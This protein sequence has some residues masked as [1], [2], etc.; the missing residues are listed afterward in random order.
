MTR[1][2]DST[3]DSTTWQLPQAFDEPAPFYAWLREHAP[4]WRVP[5]TTTS[6]VSRWNDV[7]DATSRIDDFSSN[8]TAL[9]YTNADGTLGEFDTGGLGANTQVLAVADPPSHGPQRKLVVPHLTA[10]RLAA[11]EET[12]DAAADA[13]LAEGFDTGRIEWM[14]A[15]GDRLPM[16]LVAQ[17]IGLPTADVPQLIE[18]AYLGTELLAGVHRLDEMG[19]LTDAAIAHGTYL[20]EQLEHALVEPGDDLIGDLARAVQRGELTGEQAVG[21]LVVLV[22]AGGESTAGLIGNAARILAEQPALQAQL[23][24]DL[25]LVPR[26]LEEVLRLESPFRGHYRTVRRDT[27]LAGT[28]LLAGEHL[29]LLWAAANRDPTE[30]AGPDDVDLGRRISTAHISFGRGIHFCIG[31]PLARLEARAAIGALLRATSSF[32]LDPDDPP[33]R[34]PSI[35]VR[36]HDRLPLLVQP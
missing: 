9:I 14:G 31:A 24:A 35:F 32:A 1:T 18:W 16:T 36:R 11:L 27:E 10:Q 25:A 29:L 34:V 22:G 12:V 2:D 33:T 17:V 4:V 19:R 30:F 20:A 6:L 7:V 5:G 13:L 21:S 23:R 3:R 28:T 15:V 26:F 8:L